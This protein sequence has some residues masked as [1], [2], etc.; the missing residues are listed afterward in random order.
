MTTFE[1]AV[2]DVKK[3][4]VKPSD[5]ELLRLY[6]LYKQ[7]LFGDCNTEKPSIFNLRELKKWNAWDIQRG[8]PCDKSKADYCSLVKSLQLKYGCN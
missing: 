3:L 6:G 1:K 8:K 4:K 7:S 5:I 2:E